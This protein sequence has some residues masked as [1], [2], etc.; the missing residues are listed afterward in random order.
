MRINGFSGV[1]LLDYPDK[2][3]SIIFTSP[4]NFKCPFC[5]N[6]SLIEINENTIDEETVLFEI[7]KR[8]NFIEAVEI[9]GGEPTLQN[10]LE[11]FLSKIKKLNLK[12]KI[13]TNGYLPEK[14]KNIIKTDLVDYISMD[15]KS[16]PEKYSLACGVKIDF[17]RIKKSIEV[18][19]N[20][21]VEYEFRT[22]C[23][24]G[25]VNAEDI[26]KIGEMINGAELYVLQQYDNK[27]VLFDS[28]KKILPYSENQ[29]KEFMKIAEK[30]VKK[31][32]VQNFL[33]VA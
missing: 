21:K 5:H 12:I 16:S 18:I 7:E 20:S 32:K 3:C 17:E 33:K 2:I 13:D 24:P 31:V 26:M 10:D 6:F 30:F 1:S 22:T 27:N 19:M 29:I 4:C 14:L 11:E 28:Y 23:V 9:T 15:I 8:K 25:L